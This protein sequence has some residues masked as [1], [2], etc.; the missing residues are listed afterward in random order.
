[1]KKFK[2]LLLGIGFLFVACQSNDNMSDDELR[3]LE[4][5]FEV[6]E[7]AEINETVELKASVTYGDELVEDADE[8]VFE[9]WEK[10]NR[11]DRKMIDAENEGEGVYMATTSFDYDG[12]FEMYAHTTARDLHTMPKKEVII[13]E[14]G[15]YEDNEDYEFHTEGF[16]MDVVSDENAVVN[17]E[18]ELLV[19]ITLNEDEL[20]GLDVRYEIWNYDVSDVHDWVDAKEIE[21]G[22][23]M[24]HYTFKEVGIYNLQIHVEDDDELHEHIDYEIKVVK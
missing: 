14:G 5:E 9:V 6:P 4:V 21:A 2:F 22:Q 18:T 23:Y 16:Y 13:G 19:Q 12:I 24:A 1:M 10:G 7:T 20:S 15:D 11:E 17:E 3:T 8:V